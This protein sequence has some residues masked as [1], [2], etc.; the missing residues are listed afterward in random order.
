MGLGLEGEKEILSAIYVW[1]EEKRREEKRVR[2][3]WW[4][5]GVDML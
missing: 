3:G 1:R 5:V 4:G 2:L